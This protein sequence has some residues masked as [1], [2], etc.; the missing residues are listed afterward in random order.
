MKLRALLLASCL[1]H[2]THAF[3]APDN[4]QYRG[5]IRRGPDGKLIAVPPPE[6]GTDAVAQA[7]PYRSPP[8]RTNEIRNAEPAREARTIR[9]GPAQQTR[10]LSVA[11]SMARDGDTIE[12]EAGD[13][14]ADVAIWKQDRLTI[15]GIGQARPR[16]IASGANVEGK[17][18]WVIRG[19]RITVENLEFRGARVADKNGAGIRFEKGQLTIRNCKFEDNENGILSGSNVDMQLDIENSEFGH[20]GAGDGRSHNI[21]IGA[22]GRLRVSSSYFH[23]ARTGHLLKSRAFEN[24]IFYNRLTDETGGQASYELEFPNGGIAYVVGNLIE[25]GSQTQNSNIVSFGAEGYKSPSN[26]LYLINNTLIDDR[27]AAGT[28]LVVKPGAQK[29]VVM[30]N[31]LVSP[32]KLSSSLEGQIGNNPNA[33]WDQFALPQRFDYR[34]KA[35]SPLLGKYLTPPLAN[36]V[37]LLPQREYVHPAGSRPLAGAARNP[38][39][40]QESTR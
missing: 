30:N 14:I 19:G 16:L 4:G 20:N 18:I 33:D 32:N 9:V 29:L 24:H 39:A 13:Y 6:T 1:L 3:S 28:L 27:P 37:S 8:P 40:L 35:G 2:A 7:T 15:R 26:E 23:H 11:A 17:A 21:Y 34:L 5:E 38:G 10:S 25:Q 31:L 12:V 36:G 22:I